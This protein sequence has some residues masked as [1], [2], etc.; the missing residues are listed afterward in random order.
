MNTM[1]PTRRLPQRN[2]IYT[3]TEVCKDLSL[4]D[5]P[6]FMVCVLGMSSRAAG[7]DFPSY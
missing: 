2:E 5:A 4:R 1:T 6:F 3:T 7:A